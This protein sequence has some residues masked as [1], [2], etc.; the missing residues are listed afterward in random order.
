MGICR[1]KE[2]KSCSVHFF[3]RHTNP[4]RYQEDKNKFEHRTPEFEI[5]ECECN[6]ECDNEESCKNCNCK[7][8]SC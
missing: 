6:C 3:R 4:E 2:G 1:C 7:T 8:C 5:K